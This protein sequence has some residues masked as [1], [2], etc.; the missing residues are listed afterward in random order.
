MSWIW[1]KYEI[2][3]L[4]QNSLYM[5]SLLLLFYHISDIITYPSPFVTKIIEAHPCSFFG[6][7]YF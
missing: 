6:N 1:N 7:A 3:T 4:M 2:F 5:E